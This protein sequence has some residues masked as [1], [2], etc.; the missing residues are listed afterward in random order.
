MSSAERRHLTVMFC[1]LL[2]ST[3]LASRLDPED[4][5]EVIGAY[6]VCVAETVGRFD[7]FVAKYM[8][9]GV[10]VYFGYPQAHEDD[11]ERAVRAGLQLAS[12][13]RA[14]KPRT[15]TE[16]QCRIGVD[17]GL[18]V[19]GDLV[20]PGAAQEQAIVG[21][22]P[23]LAARLQAL[24][25]PNAVVIGPR[26]R[27]LIGDL[28]EYRDLGAVELKGFAEPVRAWQVL[29]ASAIESRFEAL[30]SAALTPLVGREEE[31]ELL[32][33]RWAQA[34]SGEGRVVLLA[35]EPGI[36]KSRLTAALQEMLRGE[37]HT[38]LRYFCSPYHTDTAFYPVISQLERAAGF[39]REDA[40]ATKLDKVEILLAPTSP[41]DEDVVLLAELVSVPAAERY[42]PLDL[43]P[44]RQ[45]G[46]TF[47]AL[48]RQLELLARHR[49]VLT[50][51][52][53]VHWIDPT[54]REVL[55][56][57]IERVARLPVLLLITF[58]PE[59]QPPW[60]GQAHVTMLTLKR[61]DRREGAA[62]VE[63]IV[64]NTALPSDIVEEIVER[65]DGVPLFAEEL[66]KAVLE[67]STGPAHA[68]DAVSAAPSAAFAVPA[69][70][71]ASLMARLDRLGPAAKE[72][73]QVGA[74]IGRAFSH[75]L[76]HAVAPLNRPALKGAL[77]QLVA[78]ELLFQRGT[79]PEALYTFKHALV[80]DVAYGTLLRGQRQGLHSRIAKALEERFADTVQAHPAVLAHHYTEAGM[81]REAAGFWLRAARQATGRGAT[82]EAVAQLQKGLNA[83]AGALA[84]PERDRQEIELQ[85]ALGGA[86]I[87]AKGYTVPETD[88]AFTRARELCERIGETEQLFRALFGQVATRLVEAKHRSA[89]A[90]AQEML[91]LSERLHNEAGRFMGHVDCGCAL[92]HM[93]CLAP[94]RDHFE[95]ALEIDA[96]RDEEAAFLFIPSGRV[97]ALAF[98][99][100]ALLLLGLP[101]AGR[102]AS[103]Q[104]VREAQG[105]SH[106]TSLCVAHSAACRFHYIAN[107]K[108][109]L[110]EHAAAVARL[111]IEQGLGTAWQALGDVYRGWSRAENGDLDEGI[112]LMRGGMARYCATG[113]ALSLPLHLIALARAR[114]QA[115]D[116]TEALDDLAEAL[117]IGSANEER[118]LEAE[119]HRLTGEILLASPQQDVARSEAEFRKALAVA[120][121]QQAKL[122]ELRAATSLA[123]LQRDRGKCSETRDL[124]VPVYGWFTEGF[125]TPDLSEAKALLDELRE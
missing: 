88:K 123:R 12:A 44:Q 38:R 119:A 29:H 33:R 67:A 59:F 4:L 40:P 120:Q 112:A 63:R 10:L 106:P 73:A 111:A 50:V 107:Q 35:G 47:E 117:R 94:A 26:T 89:L 48:L 19:V 110:A 24:A 11:A 118:W 51:Y 109:A 55:D 45:K 52:E 84:Y 57:A 90:I 93:G 74:A 86:L 70:L 15:D 102:R 125:D 13:V 8:G 91:S 22:T 82:A 104:S 66:T 108:A 61:L 116:H 101:E 28:F 31:I 69:T 105:L 46:K 115:G 77:E 92:S 114:A 5:R 27:R 98:M 1:D 21:E 65:T 32:M 9:D 83:L 62:L 53:D 76:L 37:P 2:G 42:R 16:L 14:L 71:Q 124:L 23:N 3:A 79:P 39:E 80:Q 72:T 25:E 81:P 56:A 99:S 58:R 41:P 113:A 96:A 121:R 49:P 43:T 20:G 64:G 7:G 60:T 17:T 97:T 18:V 68:R 54:T 6:H 87:A 103:E 75:E 34:K 122:L 95:R 85:I 36:G 30:H 100:P 78:S